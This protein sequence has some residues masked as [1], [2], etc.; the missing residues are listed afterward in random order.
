MANCSHC[1][2]EGARAIHANNHQGDIRGVNQYRYCY[3]ASKNEALY[4][5]KGTA[6]SG[7]VPL[8]PPSLSV[9]T[10]RFTSIFH[11]PAFL[12]QQLCNETRNNFVRH[13]VRQA[14]PANNKIRCPKGS[15][16]QGSFFSL[17][18]QPNRPCP[19]SR[20]TYL[21]RKRRKNDKATHV[22]FQGLMK[23]NN[24]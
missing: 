21:P 5:R 6:I 4:Y 17:A 11:V 19:P 12:A 15:H 14:R 10:R 24:G 18:E 7:A 2:K 9:H 22:T 20:P 23:I 16:L 8:D 1:F 3:T 13:L